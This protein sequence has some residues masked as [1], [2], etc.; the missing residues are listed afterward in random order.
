MK[1]FITKA[2][3]PVPDCEHEDKTLI[4]DSYC[5]VCGDYDDV[6]DDCGE[7]INHV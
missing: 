5:S 7:R 3:Y 2:H 4:S 6:C 1:E